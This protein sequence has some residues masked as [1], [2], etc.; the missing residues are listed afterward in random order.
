MV[1]G[2]TQIDVFTRDLCAVSSMCSP[3]SEALRFAFLCPCHHSSLGFCVRVR[4]QYQRGDSIVKNLD[5]KDQQKLGQK[6]QRAALRLVHST[7]KHNTAHIVAPRSVRLLINTST[8]EEFRLLGYKSPVRT[9]QETHYVSTTE[10]SQLMLCKIWD[11]HGSDYEECRLLGYKNPVR[12]SQEIHYISTT[13]SNQLMLCKIWGFYGSDYEKCR[14]L[15]YKKPVRTSQEIH[16]ISTTDCSQL[17]LCKIW[18]FHG[19]DY[20]E[21]RLLG[22]KTQF[23]LHRRH[24][25]SPLQSSAS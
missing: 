5:R 24:I 22:Y 10:S 3:A 25:T 1:T 19:G 12:T 2:R 16:Y 17:I 6:Q 4:P 8:H 21:L 20:E 14:L 9:S 11:I 23:V 15:G 18:G 13:E 7:Y